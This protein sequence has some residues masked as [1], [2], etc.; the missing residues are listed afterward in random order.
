MI[1]IQGEIILNE[2]KK[3][4]ISISTLSKKI[5]MSRENLYKVFKRQKVDPY[6]MLRIGKAINHDFSVNFKNKEFSTLLMNP[7]MEYENS[8]LKVKRLERQLN[9]FKEKCWILMEENNLLLAGKLK[10]YVNKYS[11]ND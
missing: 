4:G 5:N 6:L 3:S 8:E 1:T 10:E 2:I 7:E 9:V 11:K